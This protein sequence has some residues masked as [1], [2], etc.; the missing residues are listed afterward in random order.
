M[1]EVKILITSSTFPR[2][3]DDS[4]PGFILDLCKNIQT[5]ARAE[6]FV[7][8]PQSEG[9]LLYENLEGIKVKR[10]RYIYPDFLAQ[11]SGHGIVAKIK[12]NKSLILLVPLFFF[13]Q[14][15]ST[16]IAIKNYKPDILLANWIIP[17]GV[18]ALLIKT[19]YAPSLKMILYSLGGDVGLLQ[20]NIFLK[21]LGSIIL[22][23]ADRIVVV[24]S[25]L[26]NRLSE[27]YPLY[28]D[29]ISIIPLGVNEKRFEECLLKKDKKE[30]EKILLF[31]GRLEEKKGVKYL[32]EAIKKVS[33]YYP[34]LILKVCGDGT[35]KKFLIEMGRKLEIEKNVLFTGSLPHS[36]TPEYFKEALVFIAPSVNLTDDL[37]GLPTVVLEAIAAKVPVITTDAGGITD[38]I[39]N[40]KTGIIVPQKSVD[41]LSSRIIE[42]IEKPDLRK[43]LADNAYERLLK[44]FTHR[45]AGEKFKEIIDNILRI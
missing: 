16:V 4:T 35:E 11:I 5:W 38:I 6:C 45:I 1:T 23:K 3:K 10:Y 31:L 24:S 26:K 28:K 12:K 9:S 39:E 27:L 32:L 19:F 41:E 22:Q 42:L 25:F 17:Q 34:H 40:Y 2:F 37:E 13:F 18:I 44:N 7:L 14:F 30:T 33:K 36:K 20:K 8:A 15:I 43:S 21:Y 29:K